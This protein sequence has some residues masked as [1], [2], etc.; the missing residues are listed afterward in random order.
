MHSGQ[1]PIEHHDVVTGDGHMV[2]RFVPVED[3]VDRHPLLA[4][5]GRDRPR[6]DL[7]IFNDEDSHDLR[8]LPFCVSDI[9][10]SFAPR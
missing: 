9:P 3:D 1:V 7:V 4:Q 10:A 6:Q 2:E 8:I 5:S